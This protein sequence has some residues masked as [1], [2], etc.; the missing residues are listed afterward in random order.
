MTQVL[1]RLLGFA[2]AKARA[3]AVCPQDSWTECY[4]KNQL[5]PASW[6]TCRRTVTQSGSCAITY[7]SWTCMCTTYTC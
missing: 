2:S 3:A 4:T 1:D 6:T 5:G 7:G